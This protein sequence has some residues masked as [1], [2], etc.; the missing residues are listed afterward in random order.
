MAQATR[1]A[2]ERQNAACKHPRLV[3]A[4]EDHFAD[5]TALVKTNPQGQGFAAA[6]AGVGLLQHLY[7]KFAAA[8]RQ[9]FLGERAGV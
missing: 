2:G 6:G 4:A 9:Q 5:E 7:R 3:L 1:E 8:D